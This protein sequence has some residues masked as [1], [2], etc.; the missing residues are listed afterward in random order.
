MI[1][2]G[3][4]LA[5]KILGELR[6]EI[7]TFQQA[8]GKTLRLASVLVGSDLGSKKFL[9]LK[10][11]AAEKIGIDFKLYEFPE[12]I[13]TQK[14][15][16]ELNTICKASVN[17]GVLIE[18]PLPKHINT[19]AVLNVIP[20]EKDIDVLSQKAQGAFFTGRSKILPP[21]VEAVKIIF[22]EQKIKLKELNAAVFGYGLLVGKPIAHWL[23][24]EE[25]TVSV[26]NEFTKNPE[27]FSREAD[28]VI[29]GIGKAE[30][31]KSD[32]I[33]KDAVVI[34]FGYENKKGKIS[35]DVDFG[36]VSK[37]ASLITPVPGGV[38]P[39]VIAAVLKNLL[40]L[41]KN[42]PPNFGEE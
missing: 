22:E 15:R 25:V 21:S 9:E 6:E 17:S 30:T 4:K 38:G 14:L 13:S 42:T 20:Q 37:K 18:L 31:I 24:Q 3:K 29:S 26:I 33:K 32:M 28:L 34:D 39:L 41:H 19:Q 2:N 27:K 12:N 10:Q 23:L 16:K 8:Q 11:K 5:D 36:S 35:G 7:K 1:I 40:F